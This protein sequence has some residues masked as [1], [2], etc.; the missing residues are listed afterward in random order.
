MLNSA[1][2]TTGGEGD[3]GQ[4]NSGLFGAVIVE[5]PGL[6]VP[7]PGDRGGSPARHHGTTASGLPGRRLQRRYPT[8]H[9]RAGLPDPRHAERQPRS[10]TPT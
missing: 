9:P 8:G 1:G 5:P 2:A 6:L 10:F 7:Q 4:I 3:G